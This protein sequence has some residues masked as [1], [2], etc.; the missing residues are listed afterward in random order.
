MISNCGHDEN[1][2]YRGGKAGDQTGT[3][4][5]VINWYNRPWKCVLRH[6][7]ADVR[8]MIASMAKAAANNNLIGY[9][10]SQ[11]GTF[12]T[13]LADS[14]YDPAQITV[15]CEADCS[16]GVAAI[17]KGAG[18]RLGID[19]LKKV[20]TACYTE[21]LRAALK[22][23]GFEVL[24]E[25]KYLT[26]DAYLFAGDILLNDNAHVATNLTTGSKASGT[27]APSKSINEVAK[28][29]IN[30]KWGNGS[31]RTNRLAAAGYDA[32][33]VQNEVNRILKGNATTPSKSINEVAKEVINGKWG[34]GS[35]RTNR[36]AAAGYDAK[37]VQNE[38]NRILR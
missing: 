9:D 26:S 28:E 38:V 24:T 22:A 36:L 16:S 23:A 27:S 2:R 11:R 3:E 12:W 6:P 13:N 29:V 25:S 34:N 32:K 35:D 8:A 1:N 19:A 18:Y 33:A 7:N 17:V 30:G 10:Q 4:W 21:N 20:S 37:A 31:D 15:A 14:N 5:R